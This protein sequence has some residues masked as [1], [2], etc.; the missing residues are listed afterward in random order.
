M[1]TSPQVAVPRAKLAEFCQRWGVTEVALFG[2]VLRNDFG[3]DSDVDILVTF[4]P[5]TRYGFKQLIAMEEELEAIFGREVD[6]L[7][8]QAVEQ[9]PNYIRRRAIL[10]S[11]EVVYA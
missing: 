11:S 3:A 8:K 9:S 7:D 1:K 10:E 2:S 6:L 4:A 5:D